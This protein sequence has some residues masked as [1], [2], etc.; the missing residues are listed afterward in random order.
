MF[1]KAIAF[2]P[3]KQWVVSV[4]RSTLL[5]DKFHIRVKFCSCVNVGSSDNKYTLVSSTD[6]IRCSGGFYSPEQGRPSTPAGEETKKLTF[7][8][9]FIPL[10]LRIAI[11]HSRI[12][13][14]KTAP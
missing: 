6:T 13:T 12:S 1:P 14:M 8:L 10:N 4:S 3:D 2:P 9:Q 7:A 11:K 5:N